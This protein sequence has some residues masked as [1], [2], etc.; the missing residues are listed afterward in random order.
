M[1]TNY[2]GIINDEYNNSLTKWGVVRDCVNDMVESKNAN[3]RY[4]VK[5]EHISETSY[6]AFSDRAIFVNYVGATLDVL[7]GSANYK[8]FTFTGVD[9]ADL[10]ES[11]DYALESAGSS[12]GFSDHLKAT[13]R[14]VFAVGRCLHWVMIDGDNSQSSRAEQINATAKIF[15]AE[16]IEDWAET[17]V[18]GKKQLNYVKLTE[19]YKEIKKQSGQFT[20]QQY[21]VTYE[22]YLDENGLF[23]FDVD[24]S[25]MGESKF[26][27]T[28]TLGNGQRLDFIPVQF[29][30]SI[31]NTPDVDIAP[32]Y[33]LA[34]INIGLYNNSANLEQAA[35]LFAVPTATFSLNPDVSIEE[36]KKYNN[37]KDGESPVF[38]G[39]AYIGCEIGLAQMSLDNMLIEMMRDKVESMARIGAQMITIGQNETA[40]AAR[41]RKSSGMANLADMVENIEQGYTNVIKWMMMF[42][43][44]S[45]QPD[46]FELTLNRVF[47]DDKIDPQT[48]N[49][50]YTMYLQGD[51]PLDDLFNIMQDNGM[52]EKKDALSYRESLGN[53]TGG[54]TLD[55]D[56]EEGT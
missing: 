25:G 7:T 36:F 8:P 51:Y 9:G 49:Q 5:D 2:S 43:N 48:F 21:K 34:R 27:V 23:A 54:N 50:L 39:T 3:R 55:L 20:W 11:I 40:E 42:N 4:I 53:D 29:Y 35:H 28:P 46:E 19:C 22:L 33:K 24:D 13:Q 47:Y 15:K 56:D 10:P 37:L 52:T 38:G 30:G 18:N 17:T 31:D 1:N 14:E 41:I 44:A 12:V 32:L 16:Q 6:N 26:T 45:G